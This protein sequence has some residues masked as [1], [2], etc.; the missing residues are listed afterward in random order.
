MAAPDIRAYRTI[1]SRLIRVEERG[2]MLKN[3]LAKGI[4]LKDEEDFLSRVGSKFKSRKKFGKRKEVLG[5][6]MREKIRDNLYWEGKTRS[7]RNHFLG[8]IEK[9]LGRNSK[10]LYY[11]TRPEF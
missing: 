11:T 7:L 1:S 9:A 4:G 5:L 8:K 6:M 10:T 3:L 2:I